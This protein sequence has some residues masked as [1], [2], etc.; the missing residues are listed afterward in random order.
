VSPPQPDIPRPERSADRGAAARLRTSVRSLAGRARRRTSPEP[1]LTV[2]V[3]VYN[4]E[5]HVA[6]CLDSVLG[7]TLAELEVIAVDDGSTDAS[8]AILHEYAARDPRL[9][10]M[11]Q[12]N[13]GQGIARNRAVAVARGEFLTFCDSDDIVPP[14]AYAYMVE[15]LRRTGS[16]FCVGATRRFTHAR[17]FP[18]SWRGVHDR[19]VLGTTIDAF[20][21]AMQDI[22]AC[23]RMFRTEF[24]RER[25]TPFRGHIAYEDHV[26]MLAAYV[27]ARQFDVL[28]RVTYLWRAREDNTSTGQQK[29]DLENLLDR[30]AVKE[31]ARALLLAEASDDTYDAWVARTIGIDY[32]PFIQYALG[33]DDMYRNVLAAACATMFGRA[34]G[35]ALDQIAFRS[36][37]RAWLC[38]ER[39]WDAL[40]EADEHFARQGRVPR[41]HVEGPRLVASPDD[42]AAFLSLVPAH[43]WGLSSYESPLVA[44]LRHAT[45]E[46]GDTLRLIGFAFIRG[47]DT[48]EHRP[49]VSAWMREEGSGAEVAVE[50]RPVHDQRVNAAVGTAQ[51]D[52]AW[53]GLEITVP[54][55]Q[56]LPTAQTLPTRWTLQLRLTLG[57]LVREGGA[58]VVMDGSGAARLP[59]RTVDHAQ[60]GRLLLRPVLDE[61]GLVLAA[62]AAPAGS[63][64]SGTA[65][66]DPRALVEDV[67]HLD[68]V[69]AVHLD[70]AA[71][72]GAGLVG[73][74]LVG[75]DLDLTA[76]AIATEGPVVRLTF[77]SRV[78]RWATGVPCPPPPG[79]FTL[80]VTLAD[81]TDLAGEPSP[82]LLA[83]L[84]AV[85]PGRDSRLNLR[86]RPQGRLVVA[87][88]PALTET[89]STPR[90][91][92]LLR[93]T[94]RRS[95]GAAPGIPPSSVLLLSSQ[96]RQV[97]G[98]PLALSRALA[99]E[100]PDLARYWGVRSHATP[101]PEGDTAVV[102]GSQAWY[103][104]LRSVAYVCTDDD[105]EAYF[106]KQ[107]GQR[108]LQT[109]RGRPFK[110]MGRSLWEHEGLAP[111]RIALETARRRDLWDA[112]LAPDEAAAASYAREFEYSGRIITGG[113]P[114][115]DVLLGSAPAA[116][117]AAARAALGVAESATVVLYA[118]TYRDAF[119]HRVTAAG[120]Y[121]GLDLEHLARELGP[122]VVILLRAHPF[123]RR[124][125]AKATRGGPV[126][127]VTDHPEVAALLLAA[128]VAVLD[129][130]S[131]R[132]DW[133][134][135]GRPAIC[136]VPDL[137]H[138]TRV[139]PVLEDYAP[140][141]PGPRATTTEE[142]LALLRDVPALARRAEPDLARVNAR[143]N[144]A[145]DGGAAAR[146]VREFF[147][148]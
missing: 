15:T 28:A 120:L 48:A 49:V 103:D 66:E 70:A 31:E 42:E 19:D 146:A 130:S 96:G 74:S 73:A 57:D 133:A 44:G 145:E 21:A 2:V 144:A 72:R 122:D 95:S 83:E 16:D 39:R 148:R 20:P 106:V 32:Q 81:G 147:T 94:Y 46:H 91:R 58:H 82:A 121:R 136:F 109:F 108:I 123:D 80:T 33:A 3:P 54:V 47:L 125:A 113:S 29:A 7:Q 34:S 85:R 65:P 135:T 51:A 23:N 119:S 126:V 4:V 27:R 22:I 99:A 129:Y 53:S 104:V 12:E 142:V 78:D 101:V 118:P 112:V 107:P 50:T 24:W 45:W 5:A 117:R 17:T 143:Y 52:Y 25:V 100:R 6:A 75:E 115:C 38:A 97:D 116:T 71:L 55:E 140:T 89:E 37:V 68:D 60:R 61:R 13:S 110:S 64:P 88:A 79:P 62:E 92:Q 67:Q 63:D 137:D 40:V 111:E 131:L 1:V 43:L 114:R 26:P 18:K 134:L 127:N 139:R 77:P 69:L 141:A 59:T 41:A 87:V 98:D 30:I 128:D 138:Y 86:V 11:T 124:D 105:L 102:I 84:P 36:K 35:A 76:T 132:Y 90:G 14:R 10:V 93:D 8:L 56:L 9:R